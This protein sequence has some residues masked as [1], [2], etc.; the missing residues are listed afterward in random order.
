MRRLATFAAWWW[1]GAR[2]WRTA[3]RLGI[4][5]PEVE[6]ELDAQVRHGAG[7]YLS[8][9]AAIGGLRHRLGAFYA[10]GLHRGA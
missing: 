3:C 4:D 2:W 9:Q 6:R 1:P 5:L 7:E 8:W 10:A